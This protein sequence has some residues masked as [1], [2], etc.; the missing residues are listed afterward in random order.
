M[1]EC[2]DRLGVPA[3]HS[4]V[5]EQATGERQARENRATGYRK[6]VVGTHGV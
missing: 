2:L 5:D 6:L 4:H 1:A 3:S